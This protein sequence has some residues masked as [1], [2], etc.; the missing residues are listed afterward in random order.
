[1]S[2]QPQHSALT[3]EDPGCQFP[4]GPGEVCNRA[5]TRSG[6]PGR[7]ASYCD[8]DGHTRA[9]A[10]AARRRIQQEP[11]DQPGGSGMT[12]RPVTDGRTSVGA[13]LARFEDTAQAQQRAVAE[14]AA[15]LEQI[16]AAVTEVVSTVVDP[17]AAA[18]EAE[19][20]HREA[21]VLIAQTQ[22]AQAAAERAATQARIQEQRERELRAQ[23]DEA[24]ETALAEVATIQT[25][26]AEQIARLTADTEAT[27]TEYQRRAE[28]T[29]AAERAAR[30]ELERV[31][32]EAE[33][34][35][36]DMR[37]ELT[38]AINARTSAEADQAATARRAS[39]DHATIDRLRTELDTLRAQHHDEITTLRREAADE[40]A[41]LRRE[42]TEQ[43]TAVLTRL[44]QATSDA[45]TQ[46]SPRRRAPAKG[47]TTVT[48]T[49]KSPDRGGV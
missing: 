21:S 29:V 34:V 47:K 33:A 14:H 10:F 3:G 39:E 6:A 4:T 11:G 5:V 9:R 32:T 30:Q 42:A 23:A 26:T 45:P 28:A 43:L 8:Q 20:A 7:P 1:M 48:D 31:Q 44:D 18:F 12:E 36:S 37:G 15:Q 25:R 46:A 35:L 38:E 13:L 41:A 22:T 16:L 27:V 40:R 24:A 19:Q 49:P 2:E 17:D